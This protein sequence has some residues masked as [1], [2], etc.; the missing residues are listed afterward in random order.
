[1]RRGIGCVRSGEHDFDG[2]EPVA[3]VVCLGDVRTGKTSFVHCF[4]GGGEQFVEG[5][6]LPVEPPYV[7]RV[8]VIAPDCMELPLLRLVLCDVPQE[9]ELRRRLCYAGIHVALL[10]FCDRASFEGL[11]AWLEEIGELL[12]HGRAVV[13]RAKSD[14]AGAEDAALAEE[15]RQL[16]RQLGGPYVECSAKRSVNVVQAVRLACKARFRAPPSSRKGR[17]CTSSTKCIIH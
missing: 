17:A 11:R 7:E 15:A 13:V 5:A 6:V 12:E 8:A 1:M 3:K 9:A 16:A 10:F 4:I 14:L 2:P